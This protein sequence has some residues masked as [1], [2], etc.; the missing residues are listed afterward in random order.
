MTT[1]SGVGVGYCGV[2]DSGFSSWRAVGGWGDKSLAHPMPPLPRSTTRLCS[3]YPSFCFSDS[4]PC[5]TRGGIGWPYRRP[6]QRSQRTRYLNDILAS[7]G[8]RHSAGRFAA[9]VVAACCRCPVWRIS[10]MM[11]TQLPR[12]LLACCEAD[13]YCCPKIRGRR[14]GRISQTTGCP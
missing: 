14:H 5:R 10:C 1:Q 4:S 3:L 11:K 13:H 9:E 12:P 6:A 7:L 2:G 8:A